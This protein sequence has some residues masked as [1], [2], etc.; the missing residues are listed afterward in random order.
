[1]I[2]HHQVEWIW[3]PGH[4]GIECDK[5]AYECS[6]IGLSLDETIACNE[7]QTSFGLRIVFWKMSKILG[8]SFWNGI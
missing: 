8:G 1:M 7:V 5:K 6:V 2:K 3:V 4:Q